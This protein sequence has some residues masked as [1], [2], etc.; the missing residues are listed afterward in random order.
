MVLT[1]HNYSVMV[2]S[3]E[4]QRRLFRPL[5]IGYQSANHVDRKANYTPM[6][7]VFQ[8]RNIFQLIMSGLDQNT[9]TEQDAIKVF[10]YE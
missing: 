6:A 2:M 9:L 3:S 10:Q 1:D 8:L 7:S 4:S 5:R